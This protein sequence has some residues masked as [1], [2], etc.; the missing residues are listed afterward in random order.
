MTIEDIAAEFK[1][2]EK[3]LKRLLRR[4]DF[5]KANESGIW[6]ASAVEDW[7]DLQVKLYRD[8]KA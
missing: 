5:P 3:C 1:L 8:F 2:D 6:L 4:K 7:Y